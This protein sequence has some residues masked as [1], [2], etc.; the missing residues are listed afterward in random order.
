MDMERGPCIRLAV[1]QGFRD[2]NLMLTL[3]VRAWESVSV[4]LFL[5]LLNGN[6][7]KNA[8]VLREE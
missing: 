4:L 8:N 5:H 7:N 6:S 3:P 1:E 2:L